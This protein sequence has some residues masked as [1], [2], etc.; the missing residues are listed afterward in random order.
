[1]SPATPYGASFIAIST[2]LMTISLSASSHP[3]IGRARSSAMSV[4]AAPNMMPK[5]MTPS[6]S[7]STADF[8]GLRVTMLTNVSMPKFCVAETSILLA[9]SLEYVA[10]SSARVSGAT[11]EPGRM[12]CTNTSPIVAA[13]AVVTKK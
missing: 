1:M 13:S 4:S 11:R 5:K 6:R 12:S 9:A 2:I 3:S 10:S 8:T 7:R